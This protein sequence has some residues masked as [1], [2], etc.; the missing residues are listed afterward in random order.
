[1]PTILSRVAAVPRSSPGLGL[2]A[3]VAAWARISMTQI[4]EK[5]AKRELFN[6][7][8]RTDA[9]SYGQ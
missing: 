3:R 2:K 7:L 1:M 8:A 4:L 5:P 9:A 6:R